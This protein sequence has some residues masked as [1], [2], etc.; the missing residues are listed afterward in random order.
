MNHSEPHTT[1][2]DFY[3]TLEPEDLPHAYREAARM[4]L[5][6]I[7][8][9]VAHCLAAESPLLGRIQIK[10]ALGIED[11]PMR[12]VAAHLGVTV[13]CISRGAKEFVESNKLPIPPCM[14]SCEASEV[15]RKAR[16][17]QLKPQP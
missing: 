16:I 17:K 14:K 4:L 7:E 15:Y 13:A 1:T 8:Q 10:Y 11:R 9:G 6:L 12:Q 3:N 2:E 5:P